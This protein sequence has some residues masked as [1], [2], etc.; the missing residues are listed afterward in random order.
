MKNANANCKFYV[1]C[2]AEKNF[3]STHQPIKNSYSGI[4]QR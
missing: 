3:L 1:L 4:L 2:V